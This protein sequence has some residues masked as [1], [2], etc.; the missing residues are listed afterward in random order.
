MD[1]NNMDNF[2]TQTVNNQVPVNNNNNAEKLEKP[3][4]IGQWVGT[5]LLTLIPC[6]NLILLIVWAAS[7]KNKSKQ[8]WAIASFIV[9]AILIALYLVLIFSFGKAISDF[10]YSFSDSLL[11]Y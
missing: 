10:L 4:S 9:S 2:S 8:N 3:Y 1:S 11:M 6:V 5:M 7:A